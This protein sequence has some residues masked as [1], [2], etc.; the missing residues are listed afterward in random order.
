MDSLCYFTH[1]HHGM[2]IEHLGRMGSGFSSKSLGTLVVAIPA[3]PLT[4]LLLT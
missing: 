3:P 4:I 2:N 1:F